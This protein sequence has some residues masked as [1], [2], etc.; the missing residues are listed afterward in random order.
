MKANKVVK[1][2]SPFQTK[3]IPK[4]PQIN[5]NFR[6]TITEIHI[7]KIHYTDNIFN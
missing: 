3:A 4:T 7:I 5:S 1:E 6:M 2:E